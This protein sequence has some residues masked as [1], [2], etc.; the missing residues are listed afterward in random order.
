M[1]RRPEPELASGEERAVSSVERDVLIQ[2]RIKGSEA[3][4][5][6]ADVYRED[7][8]LTRKVRVFGLLLA[9]INLI[10]F[11]ALK[12]N[13]QN[14]GNLSARFPITDHVITFSDD[15]VHLVMERTNGPDGNLRLVRRVFYLNQKKKTDPV[16]NLF[17]AGFVCFLLG[18][19]LQR[20]RKFSFYGYWQAYLS[21]PPI[22]RD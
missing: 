3:W 2:F 13:L 17:Q 8:D 6:S 22:D 20:R 12:Q 18:V 11:L 15:S 5:D 19:Q 4:S 10:V 16:S 9:C 1:R 7:L 14:E 21:P